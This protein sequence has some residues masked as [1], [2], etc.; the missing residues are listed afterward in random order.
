MAIKMVRAPSE[1]PNINNIDDIIALR[2]AYGDKN[3]YVKNR[4]EE[5]SYTIDGNNFIINS[6]RLVLQGVECDIDA[7]GVIITVDNISTKRYY[8]VYLEVNLALNTSTIKTQ[9]D[10]ITFPEIDSGDDFMQNSTGTAR[11]VIYRFTA[12]NGIIDSVSKSCDEIKYI[13]ED[14]IRFANVLNSDLSE[15]SLITS[16]GFGNNHDDAIR[17]VDIFEKDTLS[18]DKLTPIVKKSTNTISVP[19]KKIEFNQSIQ[20]IGLYAVNVKSGGG[21]HTTLLLSIEDLSKEY[22][23]RGVYYDNSINHGVYYYPTTKSIKLTTQINEADF[24]IVDI[25]QCI[26]Y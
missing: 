14:Y 10:T 8:T 24:S 7:S 11:L 6:G 4:G 15:I 18:E 26:K 22:Y 1:T 21:E 5:I 16:Y 2:Y 13:N 23:A 20:E 3:G 9:H 19:N 25:R 17:L 12:E